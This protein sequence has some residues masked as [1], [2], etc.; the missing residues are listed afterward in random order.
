MVNEGFKIVVV[1]QMETPKEMSLRN[2]HASTGNKV[3]TVKREICDVFSI[4]TLFHEAMLP[5]DSRLLLSIYYD[6]KKSSFGFVYTDV[7]TCEI[8]IGNWKP[9]ENNTEKT[10]QFQ[11]ILSSVSQAFRTLLNRILPVEIIFDHLNLPSDELAYLK[12]VGPASIM[13]FNASICCSCLYLHI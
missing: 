10:Q 12:L 5:N 2:Q 6:T 11:G 7:S 8:W 9:I 13:N 4:G 3:K 1:E